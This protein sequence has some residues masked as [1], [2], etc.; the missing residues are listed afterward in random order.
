MAINMPSAA[1]AGAKWA[2]VTPT[3]AQYY[4]Q[5]VQ[6][7]AQKWQ[8]GVD[9]SSG[10]WEAGVQQ[11]VADRRYQNGVQGRGA[12]YANKASTIGAQRWGQGV[13]QAAPAYETGVQPIFAAL[14]ALTLPPKGPRGS[15]ANLQRVQAVVDAERAARR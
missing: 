2:Q 13:S 5:G 9:G 11:A 8:S 10:N 4:T 1:S 7:S 14:S 3:R 12:V 6:G 15:A